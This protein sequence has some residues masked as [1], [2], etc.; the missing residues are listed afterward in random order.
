MIRPISLIWLG[1]VPLSAVADA[2]QPG[3]KVVEY[4]GYDDCLELTN[5][6]CRVVLCP[7]AGGARARVFLSRKKTVSIWIRPKKAGDRAQ[8]S[9]PSCL[10][11]GSTSVPRRRFPRHPKLWLGRWTGEVTGPRSARL[12]SA[13]GR[14]DR[15]ASHP[16]L[17]TRR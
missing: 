11:A 14:G 16:R 3:A 4:F 12:T 15:R 9:R 5:D 2:A 13:R 1:L 17:H 8:P 10:Q 6:V 7:A